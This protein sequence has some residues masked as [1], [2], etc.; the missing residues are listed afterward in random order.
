MNI[1]LDLNETE[2]REFCAFLAR[3]EIP[4][5]TEAKLRQKLIKSIIDGKKPQVTIATASFYND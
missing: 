5:K 3:L 1:I 4:D 2:T